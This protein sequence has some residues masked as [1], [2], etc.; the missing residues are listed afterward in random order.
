M[1]SVSSGQFRRAGFHIQANLLLAQRRMIGA[2]RDD[3]SV[4]SSA[5]PDCAGTANN[6]EG[7]V[8]NQAGRTLQLKRDGVGSEGTDCAEFICN[9]ENN[10]GRVRAIGDER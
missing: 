6:G 4:L 3:A 8:S 1:H 10:P 5:N 7:I 2:K 9:C